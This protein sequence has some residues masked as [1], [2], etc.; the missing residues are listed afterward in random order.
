MHAHPNNHPDTIDTL[1]AGAR[2]PM[3]RILSLPHELSCGTLYACPPGVS[4]EKR[5]LSSAHFE[6]SEEFSA[7]SRSFPEHLFTAVDGESAWGGVRGAAV[8]VW[9]GQGAAM[10][11]A[12][13]VR[14]LVRRETGGL[15]GGVG[16]EEDVTSQ[17]RCSSLQ[18]AAAHCSTL[19]H[20]VARCNTLQH[21][22][23]PCDVATA[24]DTQA[25]EGAVGEKKWAGQQEGHGEE[26]KMVTV[27]RVTVATTFLKDDPG[28]YRGD[29]VVRL[30]EV[31]GRGCKWKAA[32]CIMVAVSCIAPVFFLISS[33][34]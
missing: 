7:S 2:A 12:R 14:R 15:G 3:P 31:E 17:T 25:V 11:A 33:L 34:V 8:C 18:H 5:P 13:D 32:V 21:D 19:Q 10:G 20:T 27:V 23:T 4:V 28:G 16:G 6:F 9:G 30:G 1:E 29:V 24:E 26:K 22:C